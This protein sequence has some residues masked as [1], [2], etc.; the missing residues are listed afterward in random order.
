M[1]PE[2]TKA[3]FESY[4]IQGEAFL[5]LEIAIKNRFEQIPKN[6]LIFVGGSNFIIADLL[7]LKENKQL[8]F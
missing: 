4:G 6:E 5:N 2:K 3:I 7:K 8:P 1:K